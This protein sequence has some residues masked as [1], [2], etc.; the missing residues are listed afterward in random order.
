MRFSGRLF[1]TLRELRGRGEFDDDAT[2]TDCMALAR[3]SRNGPY[4]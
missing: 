4:I 3:N 2:R 1:Y